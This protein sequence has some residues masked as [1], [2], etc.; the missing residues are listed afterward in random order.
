MDNKE[1]SLLIDSFK[2]YRDLLAP[3]QKNLSDFVGTYDVM[4]ENIEKLNSSF[5]GDVKAKLE[6][7]FKQMST[8]SA[9]AN[10]LASQVEKLTNSA[11][12][13]TTEVGN[14]V[15]LIDKVNSKLAPLLELEKKAENQISRIEQLLEEK[16]N[17]YD[18]KA[19]QGALDKYNNEVKNVSSFINKDVGKIIEESHTSLVDM[20]GGI[21][22]LVKKRN[23]EKETLSTL[24]SSYK[25]TENYLKQITEGRDVN[26]AYIFETLDK[27]AVSR[28][29][30]H[31]K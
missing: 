15:A 22:E 18:L 6:E 20:K 27:W 14:F 2:G 10:D 11:N 13:Y 21:D 1:L 8:Q 9:K 24:I 16:T 31:K 26:E 5:A 19:L 25:A 4:R 12:R 30:K 7:L 28:G 23:D 29:V 3:V 17:N